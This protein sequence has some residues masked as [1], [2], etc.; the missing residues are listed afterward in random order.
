[1]ILE[2]GRNDLRR[3]RD[4]SRTWKSRVKTLIGQI[5]AARSDQHHLRRPDDDAGARHRRAA[6]IRQTLQQLVSEENIAVLDLT[7]YAL[8]RGVAFSWADSANQTHPDAS[9]HHVHRQDA[10]HPV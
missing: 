1:M 10:D 4:A 9:G 6:A 2:L 7:R 5:K 8:F 3:R